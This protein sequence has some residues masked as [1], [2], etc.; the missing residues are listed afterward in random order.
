MSAYAAGTAVLA[1]VAA[2]LLAALGRGWTFVLLAGALGVILAVA[3]VL[4]PGG[5]TAPH[6]A[7]GSHLTARAGPSS[8]SG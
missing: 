1:P 6:A 3:A 7:T 8:R 2:L 5:S 4:V